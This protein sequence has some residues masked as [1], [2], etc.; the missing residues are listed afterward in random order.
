MCNVNDMW[1]DTIKLTDELLI[2]LNHAKMI[3]YINDIHFDNE[4]YIYVRDILM[5]NYK[6]KCVSIEDNKIDE[7]IL[8]SYK[9]SNVILKNNNKNNH[10]EFLNILD[11]TIMTSIKTPSFKS[12]YLTIFDH[13][14]LNCVEM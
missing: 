13:I 9:A 1:N 10:T 8:S 5:E 12:L 11:D 7:L 2:M 3:C 14:S 4:K 6:D